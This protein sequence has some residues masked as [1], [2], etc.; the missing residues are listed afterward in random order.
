MPAKSKSQ[1]RFFGMVHAYQKGELKKSDVG[2]DELWDKIKKTAGE[3]SQKS[4]K[5]FAETKHKGLPNKKESIIKLKDV[6]NESVDS[7]Y[8]INFQRELVKILKNKNL[9]QW[10]SE[11]DPYAGTIGFHLKRDKDFQVFATPFFDGK[12]EIPIDVQS[13]HGSGHI[14]TISFKS[15]GNINKDIKEYL[16]EVIPVLNKL[17]RRLK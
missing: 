8:A 7:E 2:S 6:M 1:Q 10:E 16:K 3:I 14:K 4:A 9:G 15:S 5:D 11:S 17:N 12:E 13:N